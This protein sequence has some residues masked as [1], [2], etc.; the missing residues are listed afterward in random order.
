[1]SRW[2][3][4]AAAIGLSVAS[5]GAARSTPLELHFLADGN[6]CFGHG[7]ELN[8]RQLRAEIHILM[9]ESPRPEIRLVTSRNTRYQ[10]IASVLLAFQ[11]A[12]YG[13]HL[14]FV[15]YSN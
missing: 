11:Q 5:C 3:A 13:A 15:G 6:V 10:R 7:P 2:L 9:R 8:D 12:G 1:M 4:M 14:G